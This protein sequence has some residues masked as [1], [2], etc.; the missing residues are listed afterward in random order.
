[1][2]STNNAGTVCKY[3]AGCTNLTC[4]RLHSTTI[5]LVV[6]CPGYGLAAKGAKN[7]AVV[8]SKRADALDAA[9]AAAR[10]AA[11]TAARTA[12]M[13]GA[14]V[15][16]ARTCRHDG[17]CTHPN[18]TFAHPSGKGL[19]WLVAPSHKA[20]ARGVTTTTT[21][22]TRRVAGGGGIAIT[23]RVVRGKVA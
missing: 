17:H 18:C 19:A 7:N 21:T 13:L 3:G 8:A 2:S 16:T 12:T 20:E 9:A 15:P 6:G 5:G 1:M 10:A 23:T 11:K 4:R 22:T 14:G